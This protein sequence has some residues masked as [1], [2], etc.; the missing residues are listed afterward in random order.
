MAKKPSRALRRSIGRDR[1]D[2][3]FGWEGGKQPLFTA[4]CLPTF[5]EYVP[6]SSSSQV[7]FAVIQHCLLACKTPDSKRFSGNEQIGLT[8]AG[9]PHANQFIRCYSKAAD[10]SWPQDKLV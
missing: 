4:N 9:F 1:I 8:F 5:T 3:R 10:S 2:V 6:N 7:S